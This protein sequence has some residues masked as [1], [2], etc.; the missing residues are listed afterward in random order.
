LGV[1]SKRGETEDVT[2]IN[3]KYSGYLGQILIGTPGQPLTVIFDTGSANLWVPNA[4]GAATHRRFYNRSASTTSKPSEE[5]F[6]LHYGSGA[7]SGHFCTDA[8]AIGGLE[9]SEYTFA[10]VS[11]TSGIGGWKDMTFDGILGLGFQALA[12]G[13]GP[14]VM[15]ALAES[16]QLEE[17]VFG[18][19]LAANRPG[20][21]VLGGVDPSHI[22]GDFTWVG[23][24]HPSYWSVALDAVKLGD[25]LTLTSTK[26]T[27]VDS[28][29]SG[30]LGPE[31]EVKAIALMLGAQSMQ[32][33]WVVPCWAELPSLIF[34][35]GGRDFTM[36]GKDLI[37]E[38]YDS[39]CVLGLQAVRLRTPTW[40]FGDLF[41]RKFYVQFDWGQK[42]VGFALASS[43]SGHN[44]TG[45]V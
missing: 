28:G 35:L 29:S 43:G 39:A 1:E 34:T 44:A 27:F 7:V 45:L 18:F 3:S 14:T 26:T 37:T 30:I 24:T 8:V 21:L 22:V 6:R 5:V 20:E 38:S 41:M 40:I 15:Q 11:D 23:V 12:R 17:P 16:G 32:G 10:E 33:Y 2:L 4:R 9:L 13:R 19:Y 36:A 25:L 42:R 31:Q